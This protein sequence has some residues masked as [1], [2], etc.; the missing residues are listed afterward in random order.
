ME[1]NDYQ[2]LWPPR[3]EK[4]IPK[5]MLKFYEKLG[6][7]A[8]KKKNGTCTVIFA[9]GKEVI[10]K[11]RHLDIDNGDH[12]MWSPTQEHIRFFQ[13]SNKWNV[14]V[15]ELIHS[16]VSGGP[17]NQLYVFDKI[18][19]E[20]VHLVGSTFEERQLLLASQWE[21]IADE[22]DQT[23]VS[24]YVSI[25]TN[26]TGDFVKLFSELKPE[27]EGLVLKN[28]KAV[29][30]ACMKQDSNNAWQIKCRIATTNYGF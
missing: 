16:K 14:Y 23:R 26:Y 22:G 6:F 9:R 12:R 7:W 21:P 13:G 11:T 27:D 30:K 3:P 15:A 17:K 25:A 8:Q 19:D 24:D 10:F 28:P 29:L 20:G 2:Y 1:Y 18:V 5:D 4:K